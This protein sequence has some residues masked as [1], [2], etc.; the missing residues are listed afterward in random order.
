MEQIRKRY[1]GS[2]CSTCEF[3]SFCGLTMD[4]AN[5]SS[6]SEYVH[7]LHGQKKVSLYERSQMGHREAVATK[8]TDIKL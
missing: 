7:Y 8:T 4:K 1:K 3:L 6:C 5:I 2:I